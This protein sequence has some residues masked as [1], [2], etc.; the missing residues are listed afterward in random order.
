MG[1]PS[2]EVRGAEQLE[3]LSGLVLPGGESTTMLKLLRRRG[4]L[5]ALAAFAG[6]GRPVLAT[7]AGLVI[8]AHPEVGWLDVDVR[9]NAYGP[10]LASFV[11]RSDDGVH[12]L[13]FIRAPKIETVGAGVE[14]LARHHGDPVL[15][16]QGKVVAA[17]FHPELTPSTAI[18]ETLVACR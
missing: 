12:E 1:L 15:V 3:M 5:A 13:V 2:V 17:T 14:V 9:R 11:D 18:H 10:Q 4:M 16:R 6:R 7:C 8:A